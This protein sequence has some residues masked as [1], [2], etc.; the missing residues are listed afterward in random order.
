MSD[1]ESDNRQAG[2]SENERRRNH[3]VVQNLETRISGL[4]EQVSGINKNVKALQGELKRLTTRLSGSEQF[5]LQLANLR[6][7]F[8]KM[9]EKKEK[10][11]NRLMD[12]RL[13]LLAK[14]LGGLNTSMSE[15]RHSTAVL[16]QVKKDIKTLRDD[17]DRLAA[18]LTDN[19][20]ILDEI[21][22]QYLENQETMASLEA[23]RKREIKAFP[24]LTSE[25]MALRKRS[26]DQRA[27]LDLMQEL[28]RK[29]TTT[30]DE[31]IA[32]DEERTAS[33]RSLID[34][35]KL[36]Q[37]EH[38]KTWREW[39]NRFDVV[40]KT[41]VELEN[42]LNVL[43]DAQRKA[44]LSQK[45]LDD[46]TIRIERRI[47]E[48]AEM[49]RLAEERTHQDWESYQADE[50]KRWKTFTVSSDEALSES[51][52]QVDALKL[53]LITLEDSSKQMNDTLMM[54]S[55]E[56]QKKLQ[57]FLELYHEW[58]ASNSDILSRSRPR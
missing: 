52:R 35:M 11:A 29:T 46:A 15:L 8:G 9:I 14:D 10:Q 41:A 4:E 12:E 51:R 1:Q 6:L 17:D 42:K 16:A 53:R 44:R 27:K 58:A 43:D 20:K 23:S 50:G 22:K 13:D 55:E 54:L 25:V 30:L 37:Y 24:E 21:Q 31:Y 34:E 28:I 5:D 49:Q 39:L 7:D 2:R 40:N 19:R 56:T 57:G 26:D 47:N 32:R 36:T 45:G 3:L 18:M 38:D 48:I 33:Y